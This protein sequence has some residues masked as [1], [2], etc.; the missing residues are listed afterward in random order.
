M[1]RDY[2]E[3]F[4]RRGAD[5]DEAAQ[6]GRIALMKAADRHDGTRGA[7]LAYAWHYVYF[8]MLKSAKLT[9]L[10]GANS[11]D[12]PM[13]ED[14]DC[15]MVDCLRSPWGNPESILI[16]FEEYRSWPV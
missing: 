15:A 7:F 12:V 9:A 10:D 5:A 6:C 4:G 2:A 16:A 11:I 8:A 1:I 14:D 3:T 13:F